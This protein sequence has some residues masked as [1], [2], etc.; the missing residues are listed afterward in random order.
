MSIYHSLK[1]LLTGHI[2]NLQKRLVAFNL[3]MNARKE[4]KQVFK[5]GNIPKLKSHEIKEA[6][7]F[8]KSQGYQLKNTSW[9]RY[10]KAMSGHFHK[11]YIPLDI[12][13]SK[14]SPRLNQKTQWPALLDKNLSYNLF[15]DFDQPKRVLQNINGLYYLNDKV[16]DESEAILKIKTNTKFLII[17][18]SIESGGGRMVVTFKVEREITSYKNMSIESLLKLYKKDF[19]VQE[20]LEQSEGMKRLNPTSLNTLRVL[21]Y[22]NNDG[23]HLLSTTVRIGKKGSYTDNY[24]TGGI[25]CGAD[26]NGKLNVNGY[27]KQG[28]VVNENF[29]GIKFCDCVIPNYNSVVDMVKSMHVKVPYFKIISWDIAINNNNLPIMVEYNTYNQGLDIQ[30]PS[31]PLF[32]EFTKEILAKGLE[33]Y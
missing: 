33:P 2:L 28:T 6:K 23:V 14:I 7:A 11:D 27:T 12:F 16:V 5:N 15:K 21:S 8:F 10:Y 29:T 4:I 32:G 22:L 13:K 25:L 26:D 18:P 20:F 9:H 17:K 19:I 24:A 3:T 30:I 1:G 31:G